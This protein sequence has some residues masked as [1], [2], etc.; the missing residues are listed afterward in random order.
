MPV[1]FDAFTYSNQVGTYPHVC[2]GNFLFGVSRGVC[3][4]FKYGGQSLT[5]LATVV[6]EG[7]GQSIFT[8]LKVWYLINPP[9]GSNTVLCDIVSS[10]VSS[11]KGVGQIE[12]F[13]TTESVAGALSLATQITTLVNGCMAVVAESSYYYGVPPTAGAGLTM[14]GAMTASSNIGAIFDSGNAIT[15]AGLF[16]GTTLQSNAGEK[17]KHVMV[18]LAPLAGGPVD[19]PPKKDRP[20]VGIPTILLGNVVYATPAYVVDMEWSSTGAAILEGSMDE[21]TWIPLGSLPGAGMQLTSN[22]T[23]QFIRPSADITV[24]LRKRKGKF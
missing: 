14:R 18:S 4:T 2:N 17:I 20:N 11:Y 16:T 6:L 7:A 22:I 5:L 15:P 1:S 13:V 19:K 9:Q 24:M 10:L 12:S 23:V 8:P 3:P 21:I